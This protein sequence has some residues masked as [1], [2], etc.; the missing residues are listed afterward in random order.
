[1]QVCKSEDDFSLEQRLSEARWKTKLSNNEIIIQDDNRPGLEP[2]SWIRLAQYIYLNKLNIIDFWIEFRSN[3]I[4]ILPQNAEGYFFRK[5]ILKSFSQSSG[6]YLIG[7]LKDNKVIVKHISVP[8]LIEQKED[9][10]DIREIYE[11][12]ESLIINA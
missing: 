6:Q 11:C 5:C 8:E 4:R 1:M 7:Y 10:E 2:S 12:E 3:S 9:D